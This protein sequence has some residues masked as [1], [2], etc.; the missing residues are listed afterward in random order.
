MQVVPTNM[1]AL[2][3]EPRTD[4]RTMPNA[5]VAT[6]HVTSPF[7]KIW[8]RRSFSAAVICPQKN[9]TRTPRS[10]SRFAT[11]WPCVIARTKTMVLSVVLTFATIS[12]MHKREK[13]SAKCNDSKLID[14][15]TR[16]RRMLVCPQ[17]SC[18]SRSTCTACAWVSRILRMLMFSRT[19]G[20]SKTIGSRRSAFS[21][22][23][24]SWPAVSVADMALT[25]NTHAHMGKRRGEQWV[26]WGMGH[27]A[28][29]MSEGNDV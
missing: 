2:T 24:F 8:T 28:G 6:T 29:P 1:C 18:Q 26:E 25:G 20:N 7:L 19:N 27:A 15:L 23:C 21:T 10:R 12:C 5:L 14:L 17:K 4:E 22:K 13:N 9:T 3:N 16:K 11:S